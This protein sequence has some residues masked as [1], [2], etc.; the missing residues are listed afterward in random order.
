MCTCTARQ[1]TRTLFKEATDE[2]EQNS[3]L[4]RSV[5]AADGRCSTPELRELPV[6]VGVGFTVAQACARARQH[7]RTS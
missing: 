5:L 3:P 7:T 4:L 2:V 1:D 6:R